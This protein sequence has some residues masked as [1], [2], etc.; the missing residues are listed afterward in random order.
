MGPS[1]HAKA[2]R[3]G[4]FVQ[5]ARV[6]VIGG[7]LG[8]Q[9]QN[10]GGVVIRPPVGGNGGNAEASPGDGG[11]SNILRFP[12]GANGGN[13][14]I[15]PGSGGDVRMFDNRGIGSA[16]GTPGGTGNG[17]I[18]HGNGGFGIP[19][20]V[21]PIFHLGGDGGS[22]G[23]VDLL[24]T[25]PG[26]DALNQPSLLV[27]KVEVI[28]ALNGRDGRDGVPPGSGG[29]SGTLTASGGQ[30]V[31]PDVDVGTSR[32]PGVTGLSCPPTTST[33]PICD[34]QLTPEANFIRQVS[35]E[36]FAGN[37]NAFCAN[38]TSNVFTGPVTYSLPNYD[39]RAR[40][41]NH[42]SFKILG[43]AVYPI[44]AGGAAAPNTRS[45]GT[46]QIT[47]DGA[48]AL[49]TKYPCGQHANGITHC[50]LTNPLT[51]GTYVI[52]FGIMHGNIPLADGGNLYQYGFVFD[53]DNDP[54]NNYVPPP[55]FANDFFKG[56]DQWYQAQYNPRSTGFSFGA[57]R[58]SNNSSQIFPTTA[59]L[60]LNGATWF[61][62]VPASEFSVPD[63]MVRFTAFRHTGNFGL[64]GDWDGDVQRPVDQPLWSLPIQPSSSATT[65]TKGRT[66]PDR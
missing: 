19:D 35:T 60:I 65:T 2:G 44:A 41:L 12:H 42:T 23:T 50:V 39:P 10:A 51:A 45:S 9:V 32:T 25:R 55:Q 6:N 7:V 4:R 52:V 36:V 22:G 27:G 47:A 37:P 20:C 17:A 8:N 38:A 28:D 1:A 34:P 13:G 56:T 14:S 16:L 49:N 48:D 54:A 29:V 24:V 62:I 61:L 3:G 66:G 46:Y 53:R 15:R 57:R 64:T 33:N 59:R 30:P 63:P 40:A 58:V 18:R 21:L 31:L 26:E 5:G 43:G 11:S